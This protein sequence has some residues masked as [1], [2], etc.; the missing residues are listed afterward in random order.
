MQY[1]LKNKE[2][3]KVFAEGIRDGFPIGMG[4][5]AVSFSLGI[6]ARNAGITPVQGFVM[7]ILCIASAGEYAGIMVIGAMGSYL[8]IAMMTLIANARYMLMSCALSQ[9]TSP[10]TAMHHRARVAFGITDEIFAITIARPGYLNPN[11]NYGAIF[12]SANMWAIGTALGALAGNIMPES[13]VSAFSVSLFGMFLAIIIPVAK[14]D[15]VVMGAVLI[16]FTASYLSEHMPVIS[17]VS[18]GTRTIILTVV[19]AGAAA[20]LFPRPAENGGEGDAA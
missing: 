14:T 3:R 8:E 13:F 17:Q 5:L 15:K 12:I 19:I 11:Y 1:S 18:G 4:Y 10:D 20:A 16:S 2:N 7:S 9:R 6:A